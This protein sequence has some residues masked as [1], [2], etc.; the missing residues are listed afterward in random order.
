M[1][2]SPSGDSSRRLR[3]IAGL[4]HRRPGKLGPYEIPLG[5]LLDPPAAVGFG[6]R[7]RRSAASLL[8]YAGDGHMMTIARTGAGKGRSCAIPWLVHLHNAAVVLDVKGEAYQ[9]TA[10]YRRDVLG[11]RIY[12]I[13]PFHLVGGKDT[14]NP[15]DLVRPDMVDVDTDV[16]AELLVDGKPPSKVDVFWENVARAFLLGCLAH[17]AT[18]SDEPNLQMLRDLLQGSDVPYQIA[19]LLDQK[20]VTSP[21]AQREFASYLSHEG[22]KVRTSVLSTAQQHLRIL[23]SESVA[24]SVSKS[25]VPMD[26]IL[27]GEK[28]TIYLVIPPENLV[29]HGALLRMWIGTLLTVITRRKE[30]PEHNTLFL[31]DEIGQCGR[32]PALKQAITLLRGYGVQTITMWQDLAQLQ[33]NYEDWRTLINNCAVLQTFGAANFESAAAMAGI[34]GVTPHRLMALPTENCLVQVVGHPVVDLRRLDFLKDL[35]L[36]GRPRRN[37]RYDRRGPNA[38]EA[39]RD[40]ERDGDGEA[41]SPAIV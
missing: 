9:M 41:G 40:D 10:E 22:E 2:D 32:L 13:D 8:A 20:K 5:Y 24:R 14:L 21:L 6:K 31:L 4:V 36:R 18:S 30:M 37:P 7:P 34:L 35:W 3:N 19:C 28:F 27:N 15:F 38:S 1:S 39:P 12:C 26:E 29:S 17:I 11:H 23:G 33:T 25:T 16:L